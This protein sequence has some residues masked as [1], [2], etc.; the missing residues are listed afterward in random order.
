[1]PGLCGRLRD[2]KKRERER[3]RERKGG[4]GGRGEE[5]G[6]SSNGFRSTRVANI[7][8]LFVEPLPA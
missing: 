8:R 5:D 4:W 6:A 1:L 3:E 7:W 2:V